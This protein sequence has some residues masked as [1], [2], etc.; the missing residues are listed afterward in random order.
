MDICKN[1]A[2]ANQRWVRDAM[3]MICCVAVTCVL[4]V[5]TSSCTPIASPSPDSDLDGLSDEREE[6]LGTDP[7][8]PDTD[9]DALI[10]GDEIDNGSSPL[11]ADSDNDGLLDSEDATLEAPSRGFASVSSGNDIEPNDTFATATSRIIGTRT[12][13]VLEGSIDRAVDLDVFDLGPLVAGDRIIID[14]DPGNDNFQPTIALFDGDEAI[15]ASEEQRATNAGSFANNFLNEQIRHSADHY[16]FA[17]SD[18]DDRHAIGFYQFDITIERGQAAPTP[19]SQVVFFDFD[20]GSLD[21]SLLGVTTIPAFSAADVSA[22]YAGDDEEIKAAI[23]S[24]FKEN[25]AAFDVMLY[26]SDEVTAPPVEHYSRLLFGSFNSSVFGV[27]ERV[28]TYNIDQCDDGIIFT[29][30]FTSQVFGFAPRPNEL[31]VAI[32]NVASHEAGHL[33]GLNHVTDGTEIM[34]AVSPAIFLLDDQSFHIAPLAD[35]VF[36]IGMQDSETLLNESVGPK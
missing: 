17:V 20:G 1:A 25:F 4:L 14:F 8:N 23:V 12:R 36:S 10:D 22:T 30:S 31:G 5:V 29:E 35:A 26:T 11:V 33:L 9:A 32:G 19:R 16:Y 6:L 7:S 28:D 13:I 15:I 18:P 34:D 21:N 24:T 27:S 3:R 2:A